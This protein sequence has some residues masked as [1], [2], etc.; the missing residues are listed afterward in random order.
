MLTNVLPLRIGD[1]ARAVLIG[2]VPPQLR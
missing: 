2:Q 1:V